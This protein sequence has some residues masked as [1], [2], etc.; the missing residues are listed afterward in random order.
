MVVI[1]KMSSKQFLKGIDALIALFDDYSVNYSVFGNKLVL[2]ANDMSCEDLIS[3]ICIARQYQS[4]NELLITGIKNI[5]G[6]LYA[7]IPVLILVEYYGSSPK[8]G[9]A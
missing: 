4:D 3:H 5:C 9:P 1:T 7:T 8:L 6:L 2:I